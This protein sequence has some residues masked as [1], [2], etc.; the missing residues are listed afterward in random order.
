[1]QAVILKVECPECGGSG[2]TPQEKHKGFPETLELLPCPTCQGSGSVYNPAV[3]RALQDLE[4]Y[5]GTDTLDAI[6][7]AADIVELEWTTAREILRDGD[8]TMQRRLV[9][10]WQ[11]T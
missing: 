2:F 4:P 10:P 9:G 5:A 11:E 1:M 6:V 8:W 7:A 3:V